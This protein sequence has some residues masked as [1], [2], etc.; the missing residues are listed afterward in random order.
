MQALIDGQV[1]PKEFKRLA[2]QPSG[3]VSRE[4]L[5]R[6]FRVSITRDGRHL[7]TGEEMREWLPRLKREWGRLRVTQ[8]SMSWEEW[9]EFQQNRP[10]SPIEALQAGARKM[11]MT[12]PELRRWLYEEGLKNSIL[13]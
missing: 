12:M 2:F 9:L 3:E 5:E 4:T 8:F 11:G 10:C 13:Y 7:D 6:A 1:T